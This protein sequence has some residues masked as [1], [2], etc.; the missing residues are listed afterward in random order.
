MSRRKHPYKPGMAQIK[1]KPT[2]DW[3]IDEAKALYDGSKHEVPTDQILFENCIEGMQ[4]LPASCVDL[5]IADP[6][7]G[8]DFD[9][10]GSQYNRKNEFVVDGYHE[11]DGDY[12]DFTSRWICGISKIMQKFSR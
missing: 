1:F 7:F 12:D 3:E 10:K 6:P 2:F 5:I 11:I 9:G 8:I 4:S